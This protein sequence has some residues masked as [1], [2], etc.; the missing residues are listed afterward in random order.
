VNCHWYQVL[1]RRHGSSSCASVTRRADSRCRQTPR[2]LA[3]ELQEQ[4]SAR[5]YTMLLL[6]IDR[7]A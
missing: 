2:Q 7:D 5:A 1:V 6:I 4:H 3:A